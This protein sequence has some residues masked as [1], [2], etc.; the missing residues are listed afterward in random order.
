MEHGLCSQ[1]CPCFNNMTHSLKAFYLHIPFLLPCI[2]KNDM[3]ED[4][5]SAGNKTTECDFVI[6]GLQ[7]AHSKKKH[8]YTFPSYK[9]NSNRNPVEMP[10]KADASAKRVPNPLLFFHFIFSYDPYAQRYTITTCLSRPPS[11]SR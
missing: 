5:S 3:Q 9:K 7:T 10:S 1:N 2:K 11:Y 6:Y 4:L 8:A